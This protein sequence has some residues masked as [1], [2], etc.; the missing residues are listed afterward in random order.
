MLRRVTG[1]GERTAQQA[2]ELVSV[3]AHTSSFLAN[4]T[5]PPVIVQRSHMPSIGSAASLRAGPSRWPRPSTRLPTLSRA[6]GQASPPRAPP[7]SST[8]ASSTSTPLRPSSSSIAH[9]H[10]SSSILFAHQT[11]SISTWDRIKAAAKVGPNTTPAESLRSVTSD[12]ASGSFDDRIAAIAAGQGA[13]PEDFDLT[14]KLFGEML[15]VEDAELKQANAKKLVDSWE[16]LGGWVSSISLVTRPYMV[17][18]GW[19]SEV[20]CGRSGI[21]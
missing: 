2:A 5:N 10:L 12:K 16:R 17:M 19:T 4:T 15:A 11:R 8:I 20:L 3:R 14:V 6:I 21:G 1:A 18:S 7:S 9:S 13:R